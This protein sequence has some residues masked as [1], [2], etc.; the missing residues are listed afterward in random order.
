VFIYINIRR[1]TKLSIFSVNQVWKFK[2]SSLWAQEYSWQ[3]WSEQNVIL[4]STLIRAS[5]L[6]LQSSY[7]FVSELYWR[8][9]CSVY[10]SWCSP[11]AVSD[12]LINLFPAAVHY[13]HHKQSVLSPW[14]Q[15]AHRKLSRQGCHA[16][17]SNHPVL[18]PSAGW[19]QAQESGFWKDS[20]SC[21]LTPSETSAERS[22]ASHEGWDHAVPSTTCLI[23][24]G[25]EKQ[26][27]IF[28]TKK[29]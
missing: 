6:F 2:K 3:C 9:Y 8:F 25:D 27:L 26:L 16:P 18:S 23:L 24:E 13:R 4:N 10:K 19:R 20:A 7:A 12:T 11:T 15:R 29:A 28:N 21:C 1:K 14:A 17:Q 5:T 22:S